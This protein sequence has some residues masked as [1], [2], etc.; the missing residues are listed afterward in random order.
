ME[1]QIEDKQITF[2][3]SLEVKYSA[4]LIDTSDEAIII[5]GEDD[6]SYLKIYTPFRGVAKLL[7]FENE[8][9]VDAATSSA[10]SNFDLSSMGLGDLSSMTPPDL[11][12]LDDDLSLDSDDNDDEIA[13]SATVLSDEEDAVETQTSSE[14][15]APVDSVDADNSNSIEDAV[16]DESES[17]LPKVRIETSKGNII[18]ELF[19][20]EA[21]NTVANFISLA[22]SGFYN[23]LNF[24]RVIPNFMIQGGCPE[25]TGTGG[26]GYRFA[27]ECSPKRCH[28]SA[29]IL[30]MANAGP[31]TNGSQ[32]FITH[33]ETPHLDGK[34]TVFGYTVEGLDVV[35]SIEGGDSINSI[36]IMQKRNHEYVVQKL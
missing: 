20:D 5:E 2:P 14:D 31:N 27:D 1:I 19:E 3:K 23:D 16:T 28:D 24:H 33:N 13:G 26:P 35:N 11:G 18:L 9:W 4:K 6:E 36:V 21:P 25:G 22:E 17:I 8:K 30:S 32:F 29:G 7:M 12:D 10:M 15:N 34:H